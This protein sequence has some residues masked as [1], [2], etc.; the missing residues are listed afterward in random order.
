MKN[1]IAF[2]ITFSGVANGVKYV[3]GRFTLFIRVK[4][5]FFHSII[6]IFCG[7]KSEKKERRNS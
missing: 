4:I 2:L 6:V 5:N 3:L 7:Q 1:F